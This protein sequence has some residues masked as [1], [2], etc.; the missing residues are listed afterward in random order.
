MNGIILMVLMLIPNLILVSFIITLV[1]Y[2]I[3]ISKNKKNPD[4]YDEMQVKIRRNML[5]ASSV[6]MLITLA[7]IVGFFFM[8]MSA[9]AYM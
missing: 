2:C 6:A 8:L 7:V 5:I 9:V 3:A 4:T 1:L